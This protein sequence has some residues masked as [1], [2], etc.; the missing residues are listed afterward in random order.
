MSW[1]QHTKLKQSFCS[2]T[3]ADGSGGA[4]GGHL[5]QALLRQGPTVSLHMDRWVQHEGSAAPLLSSLLM[6]SLH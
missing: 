4:S 1:A 3:A 6:S 2:Q 5:A